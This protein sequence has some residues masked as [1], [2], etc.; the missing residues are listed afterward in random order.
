M[1]V[2]FSFLR[3]RH[4]ILQSSYINLYSH[5]Q[6]K[7]VILQLKKKKMNQVK[8]LSGNIIFKSCLNLGWCLLCGAKVKISVRV[9]CLLCK[10]GRL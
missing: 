4:S 10:S 3:N 6:W 1:V 7:R 2:L 5:Q 8:L 9:V